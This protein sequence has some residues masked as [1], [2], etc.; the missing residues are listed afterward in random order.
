MA[1]RTLET[2][3]GSGWPRT[4]LEFPAF[5]EKADETKCQLERGSGPRGRVNPSGDN[6]GGSGAWRL[7]P[8]RPEAPTQSPLEEG[9]RQRGSGESGWWDVFR[10]W[11]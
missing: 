4:W 5:G 3:L 8:G 2:L 10:V 9:S 7:V 11:G 6:R 1:G